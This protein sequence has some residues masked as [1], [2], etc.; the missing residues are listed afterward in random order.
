MKPIRS[1]ISR[2]IF[3][4]AVATAMGFGATQ[5]FAAPATGPGDLIG[6]DCESCARQCGTIKLCTPSSC[7]CA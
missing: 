2:G 4:L 7:E 5:A 1:R 3:A 6:G